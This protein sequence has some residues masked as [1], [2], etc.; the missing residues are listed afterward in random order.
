MRSLRWFPRAWRIRYGAELAALLEQFDPSERSSLSTRFDLARAGLR[1]RLRILAPGPLRPSDKAREG[2]LLVL[3]AWMLFV[4]GGF[5][6][7]K[8]SEHWQTATPPTKQSLPSHAFTVLYWT[9]GLGSLL[10]IAGVAVALPAVFVLLRNRGWTEIRRPVLRAAILSA[11]AA[12]LTI[13]LSRWAHSLTPAERN[14]SDA[15]YSTLFGAWFLLGASCLFAWA[16]AAASAARRL[17]LS[18]SALQLECLLAVAVGISMLVMTI[19]ATV[20][21]ASLVDV[22]PWFFSGHPV[23]ST[24]SVIEPNGV[25]ASTL[26]ASA[27]LLGIVGAKRAVTAGFERV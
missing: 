1:E 27:T 9:A 20:W 12:G 18:R 6:V 4:V 23:G 13:F 15:A 22:A 17:E 3:Y 14:G 5:G 26:I 2:A 7:E 10:V 16:A 25:V 19:A 11:L 24:G 8:L 21:W